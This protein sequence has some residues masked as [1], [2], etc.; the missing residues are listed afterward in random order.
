MHNSPL[1]SGIVNVRVVDGDIVEQSN[2]TFFD[3]LNTLKFDWLNS[4][5]DH[6][7]LFGSF[8]VKI[9]PF[10]GSLLAM[11]IGFDDD[12]CNDVG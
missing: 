1:P 12:V 6:D 8:D 2:L 9:V 5:Y 3:E 11:Y 10:N 4:G 7:A